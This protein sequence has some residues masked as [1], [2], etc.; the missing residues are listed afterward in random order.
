M[1]IIIERLSSCIAV[2]F[3]L[4]RV[5][6]I[7]KKSGEKKNGWLFLVI[8]SV[9]WASNH[10]SNFEYIQWLNSDN[11]RE[12]CSFGSWNF[13][14]VSFKQ[15]CNSNERKRYNEPETCGAIVSQLNCSKFVL[16]FR[17]FY[18]SLVFL[19]MMSLW[20]WMDALH[21]LLST[22]STMHRK[23][24]KLL[25]SDFWKYRCFIECKI[26]EVS[27]KSE[28]RNWTQNFDWFR[29]ILKTN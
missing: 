11:F 10:H 12:C 29:E 16:F 26:M 28:I 19:Y 18:F 8:T 7:K 3:W 9:L 23:Q 13:C 6:K 27:P 4:F 5:L 1:S 20:L 21:V 25:E 15:I 17:P 14:F 2:S 24:F 22:Y